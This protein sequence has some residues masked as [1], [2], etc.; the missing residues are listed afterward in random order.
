MIFYNDIVIFYLDINSNFINSDKRR[1]KKN[2]KRLFYKILI[3]RV[4]TGIGE[5]GTFRTFLIKT[6]ATRK[7]ERA[8]P[9]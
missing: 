6:P 3:C 5:S 2:I 8:L 4:D 9:T 1:L 7:L